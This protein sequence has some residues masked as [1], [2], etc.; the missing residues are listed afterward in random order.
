MAITA[1]TVIIVNKNAGIFNLNLQS[2]LIGRDIMVI[3]IKPITNH[4]IVCL[5]FKRRFNISLYFS[6]LVAI[7]LNLSLGSPSVGGISFESTQAIK[8]DGFRTSRKTG[9]WPSGHSFKYLSSAND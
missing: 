6:S 9:I 5:F 1:K 3:I 2:M 8:E 4:S 7:S